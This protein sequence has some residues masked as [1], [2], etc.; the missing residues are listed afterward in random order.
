MNRLSKQSCENRN[1]LLT[2]IEWLSH[3]NPTLVVDLMLQRNDIIVRKING[4]LFIIPCKLKNAVFKPIK[5]PTTS[6][7]N[8]RLKAESEILSQHEQFRDYPHGRSTWSIKN[9]IT[10]EGEELSNQLEY[11]IN[12]ATN[13]IQ[14]EMDES[15]LYWKLVSSCIC[16]FNSVIHVDCN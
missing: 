11:G 15:T 8:S 16:V 3:T 12:K 9:E 10:Q 2:L 5:F 7:I 14:E 4:N 6:T 1:N 13:F